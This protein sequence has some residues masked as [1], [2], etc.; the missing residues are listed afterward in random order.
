M[1]YKEITI[2]L[3]IVAIIF[4][5]S[6]RTTDKVVNGVNTNEICKV[7][8]AINND[9]I[10]LYTYENNKTIKIC[11]LKKVFLPKSLQY[12]NDSLVM[13]GEN[14]VSEGM[15]SLLFYRINIK[16]GKFMEYK[17]VTYQKNNNET[18]SL[19]TI[20]YSKTGN[21]IEQKDTVLFCTKKNSKLSNYRYCSIDEYVKQ[22]GLN[23]SV[24]VFSKRG[25]LYLNDK[26]GERNILEYNKSNNRR[27]ISGYFNPSLSHDSEKVVYV[28]RAKLLDPNSGIYEIEIETGNQNLLSDD[29]GY[30]NPKY[31]YNNEFVLLSKNKRRL[32]DKSWVEDFYVFKIKSNYAIKISEGDNFIW[33]K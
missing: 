17:K 29:A 1:H 25:S 12:V 5:C 30:F 23:S 9:G 11:D 16:S 10:Y 33:V 7:L 2:K 15:P 20:F 27:A 18:V 28:Y 8:Y 22:K 24:K 3:I 21:I 14:I 4:L 26:D 31:S 13:I 19:R 32:E 6:C